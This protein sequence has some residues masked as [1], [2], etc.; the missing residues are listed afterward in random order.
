M[1]R[2]ANT[3][4]T[5]NGK[6]T[7]SQIDDFSQ[8]L[9]K[10]LNKEH[11]SNIA[12]NLSSDEAPT[13]IKRWIPSGSRQLDYI[14]SN[15]PGGGYA[16][17]RIVEIQAQ[18]GIG[19]SHIGFHLA[20]S[21]QEMGGI[22]VYVDTENATNVENLKSLGIDVSRRFVF[23]Q[24]SCTEEVLSV[25]EST[26]K[27]ARS[28]TKDVPVAVIWDSVSQSAPKAELEG[29][30]DQNT[31][32]LQARVLSKGMRKIANVIA[33]EKVILFLVSQQRQKVGV[34]LDASTK[35][36][37][38]NGTKVTIKELVK[39]NKPV[40]VLSFNSKTNKIEPKLATQFYFNGKH[41]SI[42]KIMCAGG[43]NGRNIV[44][45]TGNHVVFTNNGLKRIDEVTT[46][47]KMIMMDFE[48]YSDE[49]MSVILGGILGDS[50][51]RFEKGTW[52]PKIRVM[53]GPEQTNYC[54]WK[55][56][57]LGANLKI[58]SR[59]RPWFETTPCAQ[60]NEF[61]SID[62]KKK[63]VRK[64]SDEIVDKLN[65][66]SLAI[67]YM[68]DGTFS[69]NYKKWGNG[70]CEIGAASLS[71]A[72]LE[73][74]SSKI[75]KLG[76]GKPSVKEGRGLAFSGNESA[77]FQAGIAPFVI[78]SMNYKI[79][80][81][82]EKNVF[83]AKKESNSLKGYECPV[84]KITQIKK[85]RGL[86]SVYDIGVEDNHSFIVNEGLAVHNSYGD[87]TTTPGG[88]AVPYASSVRIKLNGG[89]HLE[90]KDG[91]V[92]GIEVTAKTIKNKTA[93]P[94]RQCTFQIHF[95]KGIVEHENIFDYLREFYEKHDPTLVAGHKCLVEGSGAWKTFKVTDAKG[96]VV[97]EKKFNKSEFGS[98]VLYNKEF[99][100]YV[101]AMMDDAYLMKSDEEHPTHVGV[102]QN[103]IEEVEAAKD[104]TKSI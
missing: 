36:H 85:P 93:K 69:G 88:M 55:A 15:R 9:I 43:K 64:L 63:A 30:Y 32:G 38:A 31:I 50:S 2:P 46:N 1:A 16:E 70:R 17:G 96:T 91:N 54:A 23:V 56:D 103:S 28:M 20:K 41:E 37:L 21:V 59:N 78:N 97:V 13:D 48:R 5:A 40:E 8:E 80:D 99:Q 100:K 27:K 84:L 83:V 73:K 24:S 45:G 53:H 104:L 62:K 34:C 33:N 77:K 49:Q 25:I 47:D 82:T 71:K 76:L 11:G 72:D 4:P 58:D 57:L 18:P 26:I 75:E 61:A 67:W 101:D 89:K 10:Q 74:I 19:K 42:Y 102:D 79:K 12:F 14:L 95:G 3:T 51:L 52:K 39:N 65:P 22:A 7:L 98:K 60:L 29:E 81:K 66:L 35:I 90:D 6:S 87:P 92:Y 44:L 94:F 68:D 86:F